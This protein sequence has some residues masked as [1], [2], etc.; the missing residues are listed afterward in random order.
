MSALVCFLLTALAGALIGWGVRGA[1]ARA[2][3]EAAGT[4]W[5]VRLGEVERAL[6]AATASL[7]T[8]EGDRDAVRAK[9]DAGAAES[10]RL[11]TQLGELEP[12][13]MRIG[14][15]EDGL[16]GAQAQLAEREAA[17]GALERDL[18]AA[19]R[20]RETESAGLRRRI[21]EL[22]P[23]AAQL[24]DRDR[25]AAELRAKLDAESARVRGADAELTRLR[26]RVTELEGAERTR[27]A[28]VTSR[29]EEIGRLRLELE[30]LRRRPA[31]APV[32]RIVEKPVEKVVEK[33]VEKPVEKIV[34][35]DREVPVEKVVEKVVEK[36]VEKVVYRDREVPV[37]KVVEKVVEK[38]VEKVVYRDREVPVE[39]VVEKV[40]YRDRAAR[41]KPAMKKPQPA[42]RRKAKRTRRPRKPD[43]LKLIH[44]VGPVLERLLHKRGIRWFRQ[45][46]RWSDADVDR[47]Q[48][49]LPE[50]PNRI[51]RDNWRKSARAEH[52][53]KYR[54]DPLGRI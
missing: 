7:R 30:A 3:G 35:R 44:G 19:S 45:I 14:E 5:Q 4:G 54:R 16:A 36:P 49:R 10:A 8:A 48:A 32:E 29:D 27:A 18:A 24:A 23:L 43:D 26:A 9:L 50:F 21:G 1:R 33:I 42:L 6:A 53:K 11:R 38:P 47:M 13:R 31:P 46:A 39:K 34:Y 51:R 28:V 2:A 37:E 12:L 20:E 41:K 17:R 22:E 52:I 25:S 15:L 40:V